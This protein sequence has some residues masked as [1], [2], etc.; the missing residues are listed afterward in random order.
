MKTYIYPKN[1][2]R[3]VLKLLWSLPA[4]C[5]ILLLLVISILLA[6]FAGVFGGFVIV[7]AVALLTLRPPESEMTLM[8]Y[9]RFAAVYFFRQQT[10]FS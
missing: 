5:A 10:F 3:S 2:Q 1:L 7:G 8:D 4:L 6:A 9:L